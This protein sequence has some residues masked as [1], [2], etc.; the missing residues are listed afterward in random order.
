MTKDK[1]EEI[2]DKLAGKFSDFE[3]YTKNLDDDSGG[4][5]EVVEFTGPLG[6]MKLEFTTKPRLLG[7][8]T[9]YS[10]RIGAN[11]QVEKQYDPDNEV[12]FMKA[13]KQD[14]AGVWEEMNAAAFSE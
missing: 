8:K 7:E 13:Y 12:S 6:K 3:K 9:S 4:S 5:K 2:V 11:V 14:L 10:K 1:W